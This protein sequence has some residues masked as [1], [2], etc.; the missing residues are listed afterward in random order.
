MK[1]ISCLHISSEIKKE[2]V[3]NKKRDE[4]SMKGR[5]KR[6]EGTKNTVRNGG[7]LCHLLRTEE[8]ILQVGHREQQRQVTTLSET[9]SS[10]LNICRWILLIAC[11]M[12]YLVRLLLSVFN[13]LCTGIPFSTFGILKIV[14]DPSDWILIGQALKW[15]SGSYHQR[16]LQHVYWEKDVKCNFFLLML[17]LFCSEGM[18]DNNLFCC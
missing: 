2:K 1:L 3:R 15:V 10:F 14:L 5:R 7:H 6:A 17:T 8:I 4:N 11:I 18:C 13:L 16:D 12:K 9:W